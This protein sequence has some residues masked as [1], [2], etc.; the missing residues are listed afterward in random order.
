MKQCKNTTFV[1][2]QGWSEQS[3]LSELGTGSKVGN[4]KEKT[5]EIGI[6]THLCGYLIL[7][8]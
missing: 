8:F 5:S 2:I 3:E 6:Q 4:R 7:V 1:A